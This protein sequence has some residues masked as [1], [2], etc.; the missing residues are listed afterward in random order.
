MNRLVAALQGQE[1]E[2]ATLASHRLHDCNLLPIEHKGSCERH[3]HGILG[4]SS[5]VRLANASRTLLTIS[6]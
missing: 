5:P 4:E 2:Q 6:L 1:Q 3:D